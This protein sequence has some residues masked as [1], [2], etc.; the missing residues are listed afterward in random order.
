MFAAS[1]V[2][3]PHL[4]VCPK[5]TV[6]TSRILAL[7]MCV[8][9][10]QGKVKEA[11]EYFDA[12]QHIYTFVLGDS[13]PIL[14][15]HMCTLADL[16]YQYNGCKGGIGGEVEALMS[17]VMSGTSLSTSAAVG[18]GGGGGGT[19]KGALLQCKVMLLLA[20]AAARKALGPT[21]VIIGHYEKKLAL[22][23]MQMGSMK[24]TFAY[25]C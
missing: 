4:L 5:F 13:H 9:F 2:L 21:H 15:L 18:Q 12:A 22:V 10:R 20:H 23:C 14:S 25:V 19:R 3:K 17:G 6:V 8:A 1:R 16:Y 24:V 11:L 7:L